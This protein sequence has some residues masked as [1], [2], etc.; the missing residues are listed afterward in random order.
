MK[1]K[2][3]LLNP[4]PV[5]TSDKVRNALLRGD[6]CHREDDFSRIQRNVRE[7]L[8]DT[9]A[10]KDTHTAVIFT[11]SGTAAMEAAIAYSLSEGKTMLVVNNG[12]YGERMSKIASI[13]RFKKVE[14]VYDWKELPDLKEIEAALKKDPDI[15]VV[16][17]VHHETTTGL[18]NPVTEIGEI[19]KR[20]G[21]VFLVDAIS[22]L[23]GEEID[24]IK[25][26]VDIC[27]CSSNKCIQGL[28]GLSFVILKK[29]QMERIKN[30]P[31]R[32][33]YL[34]IPTQ[35]ENQE[36]DGTPFT[37]SI[38]VFYALEAALEE[39]REEGVSDRIARYK[40]ASG[41]LREGFKKL[42][43]RL[44]LPEEHLSN[45]I[46]ALYLPD[47]TSY[48]E[49]HDH[50]KKE[51]FVIYAGQARLKEKIFR[52]ANMGELTHEDLNNFLECLGKVMGEVECRP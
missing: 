19:C 47:G 37:P 20:Y 17:L 18:I 28:P 36:K 51:G 40:K 50:L 48:R 4:G 5:N 49:L 1:K 13:Y 34:H 43:L 15:E 52:V 46:T 26:G 3:V 7:M 2:M 45:T 14:L 41:I 35:W 44:L 25:D 16:A 30:F 42:G 8:T 6:I 23:G 29:E 21:R 39:L 24:L 10:R 12:I 27:M 22:S 38:P 32:S 31:P 33:M 11:G 9:F